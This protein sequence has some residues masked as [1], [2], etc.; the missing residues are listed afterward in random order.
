M[1]IQVIK[2]GDETWF[3]IHRQ[4]LT[5]LTTGVNAFTDRQLTAAAGW[6]YFSVNQCI[7]RHA[8]TIVVYC[9]NPVTLCPPPTV[10]K[11]IANITY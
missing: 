9:I 4:N 11:H 5:F 1:Q 3:V 8:G 2:A 6:H 10:I 7:Y